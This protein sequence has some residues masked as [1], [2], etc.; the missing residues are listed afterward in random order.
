MLRMSVANELMHAYL[1]RRLRVMLACIPKPKVSTI[2][3]ILRQ[4]LHSQCQAALYWHPGCIADLWLCAV[5]SLGA[6]TQALGPSV[7]GQYTGFERLLI[8]QRLP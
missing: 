5:V 4:S 2:S 1:Q 7:P 8:G 6:G 3:P